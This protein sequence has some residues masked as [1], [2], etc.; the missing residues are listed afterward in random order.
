VVR[1]TTGR[2]WGR[3]YLAAGVLAAIDDPGEEKRDDE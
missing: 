2:N 3:L 1:E